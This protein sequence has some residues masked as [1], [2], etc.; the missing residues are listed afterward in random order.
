M[1][2]DLFRATVAKY[3]E[4]RH[5]RKNEALYK[6]TTCSS[7]ATFNR[8]MARPERMELELFCEIM[9]ALNVPY[10]ERLAILTK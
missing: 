6:H 2:T 10:E 4:L 1:N 8:R 7:L 9:N 3:K 5:I